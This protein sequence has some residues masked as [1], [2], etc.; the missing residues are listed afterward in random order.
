VEAT[1]ANNI[2]IEAADIN[3][4]DSLTLNGIWIGDSFGSV[5]EMVSAINA[6]G[7]GVKVELKRDGS[8]LLNNSG[9]LPGADILVDDG[10][11][12]SIT[13]NTT[14]R[15]TI[16]LST[17]SGYEDENID[18]G[19]GSGGSAADLFK[20]GL[21]AGIYLTGAMKEDLLVFASADANDGGSAEIAASYDI[22]KA[23]P[24][25]AQRSESIA[26]TF[27]DDTHYSITDLTTDTVVAEREY[28]SSVGIR[29]GNTLITLSS[30]P[31]TGDT[32]KLD[33]NHDGLGDNQN[34]L[35]LTALEKDRTAI[36]GRQ[37]IREAYDE[38]VSTV[39]NVASQARISQQAMQVVNQ[40]AADAR[41]KASGVNM[42]TEAA[43]LMR[44]QQAYQAA[45]KSIQVANQLFDTLIQIR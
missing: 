32:F 6:A 40:Q 38:G 13:D 28:D 35:R 8:L 43:D 1:A 42:D 41:D 39:S 31:V 2:R 19:I 33:G 44:Y 10:G 23:D 20:L 7:S 16:T 17:A 12:I 14:V 15:G 18:I 27:T 34:I 45:A 3:I 5:G 22:G 29:W 25:V 36:G 4:N 21:R 37:S 30:V 9:D 26:I 11:A 24:I